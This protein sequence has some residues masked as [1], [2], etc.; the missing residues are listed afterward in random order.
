MEQGDT[1][2][3][4]TMQGEYV[5]E[6]GKIFWLAVGTSL[7]SLITLGIYRF[8]ARTRIRR[9]VW[10]SVQPGGDA[11][12]YT[13]TGLEKFLGFLVAIVFLAIYL[14]TLQILLTFVG[15]N[16]LG[17]VFAD[18]D[19]DEFTAAQLLAPYI[20]LLALLPLTL[21]AQ[22]RAR[23]YTMSRTRWRGV[24]F[25]MDQAALRYVGLGLLLMVLNV[26]TLGF[27]FP[28]SAYKL[29]KFMTDRS[30]YGTA[31]MRLSG[32][33]G[34]LYA[35]A[36]HI[37]LG[38][39]ILVVCAVIG[40]AADAPVFA[41]LGVIVGYCWI[42]FGSLYYRVHSHN[43]ITS[44]IV[45]DEQITL[46]AEARVAPVFGYY[47]AAIGV[48]YLVFTAIGIIIGAA[49][50]QFG[51]SEDMMLD[52]L[53][54]IGEPMVANVSGLIIFTVIAY[55]VALALTG[56]VFIAFAHQKIVAHYVQT[57][58]IHNA[59]HLDTIRQRAG[60]DIA[61]ADGFADALDMG[62]AF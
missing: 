40:A 43:I 44:H 54:T 19:S 22:Y 2:T 30:W 61:D 23:R 21:F 12:E 25:A 34:M 15:F 39:I 7:L 42:L 26:I 47:M 8:W 53:E 31:P 17:S 58:T 56:A 16:L 62:G 41:I 52:F 55:L 48:S 10:S 45:V 50:I 46:T 20:T 38:I 49:F 60:D 9:Y 4:R 32:K 5:G 14:G 11:F 36:F 1:T 59:D 37:F 35:A 33:A 57:I 3:P 6:L 29:E 18:P 24:R 51:L 28:Y 27:A 13:G